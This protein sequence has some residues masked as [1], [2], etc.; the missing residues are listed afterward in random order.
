[1][2]WNEP[3]GR[4]PWKG[5]NDQGPPDLDELLRRLRRR[6]RQGLGG[7]GHEPK[8]SGWTGL[9]LLL[10]VGLAIWLLSGFYMVQ[11]AERALVMRFGSFQGLRDPGPHWHW[12]YPIETVEKVN[13][14]GVREAKYRGAVLLQ[15]GSLVNVELTLQYRIAQPQHF[16]L[17]LRNGESSVRDTM[18]SVMRELVGRQDATSLI[19]SDRKNL[20]A[21]IGRRVQAV[22]DGYRAG[23]KVAAAALP[24][25]EPPE[26][27]K[28]AFDEAA[29]AQA[30]RQRLVNDAK[31]QAATLLPQ[32]QADVARQLQD[33]QAYRQ[34]KVAQ[35][36]G[37]VA[38]FAGLLKQYQQAPRVT[39]ER[40]YLETME[41]I[42]AANPKVILRSSGS[43]VIQIP[44]QQLVDHL[45]R[46]QDK[47]APHAQPAP[48]ADKRPAAETPSQEK[49]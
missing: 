34:E 38:R 24:D 42:L 18:I 33:A 29:K 28:A 45:E 26:Q 13:I 22:L 12:P 40:L 1:M 15:D 20:A 4:D 16:L 32:V 41:D 19:E 25:M 11:P 9:G 2:A 36:Q 47:D 5:R 3:G 48:E 43:N 7:R 10:A 8:L 44:L 49:R 37:E 31:A 35:A 21:A 23:V 17:N 6:L 27:V 14:D 46:R 30:E 39:R